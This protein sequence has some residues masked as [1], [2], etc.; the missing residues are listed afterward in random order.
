MVAHTFTCPQGLFFNSLT[1]GC[2]FGRNVDCEG[3][4]QTEEKI[5]PS[6]TTQSPFSDDDDEN[7]EKDPRT[8][9]EVLAAIK[10]AGKIQCLRECF[11]QQACITYRRFRPTN[12]ANSSA[13][14]TKSKI[15]KRHCRRGRL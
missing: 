11:A 4:D 12:V 6:T 1:D 5:K 14:S 7:D 10:D 2:D 15:I 3:K 13:N 8:L 9:E